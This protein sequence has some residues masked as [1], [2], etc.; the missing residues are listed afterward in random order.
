MHAS[1]DYP[2]ITLGPVLG[3]T[4]HVLVF[5]GQTVGGALEMGTQA[6]GLNSVSLSW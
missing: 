5:M 2:N 4:M 6:E 1:L 3:S